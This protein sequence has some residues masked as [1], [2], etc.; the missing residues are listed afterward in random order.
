MGIQ[1]DANF[2]LVEPL[3]GFKL[4][5]RKES[6]RRQKV[7]LIGNGTRAATA[8]YPA[9]VEI[10]SRIFGA[11]VSKGVGLTQIRQRANSVLVCI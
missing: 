11:I 7:V 5:C 10:F 3:C 6:I 2:P 9:Q 1:T 4:P 8:G